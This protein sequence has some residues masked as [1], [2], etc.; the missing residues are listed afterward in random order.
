MNELKFEIDEDCKHCKEVLKYLKELKKRNEKAYGPYILH[1]ISK[2]IKEG[3][4]LGSEDRIPG[5]TL[6]PDYNSLG[7]LTHFHVQ[8][9]EIIKQ[10]K[11]ELKG[12]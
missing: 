6:T 10:L 9:E 4:D 7:Y 1:P 12:G 2:F 8:K 3:R 11:K 5:I